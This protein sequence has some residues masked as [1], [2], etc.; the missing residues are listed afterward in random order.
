ML[1]LIR[2][3]RG[4]N[5]FIYREAQIGYHNKKFSNDNIELIVD[6]AILMCNYIFFPIIPV[7][8]YRSMQWRAHR[9][10]LNCNCT[11]IIIVLKQLRKW[12]SRRED[13]Q[14]V[15]LICYFLHGYFLCYICGIFEWI[16]LWFVVPVIKTK[17]SNF[18]SM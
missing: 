13:G 15:F 12:F 16:K 5:C 8:A 9:F 17:G 6:K 18:Q 3:L 7:I 11:I 1:N 14:K 2:P 10:K 4:N